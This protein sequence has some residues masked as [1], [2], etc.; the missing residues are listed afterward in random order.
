MT[1]KTFPY[2][3]QA[4]SYAGA[5]LQENWGRL[6]RGDCEPFPDDPKVAGCLAELPC[7]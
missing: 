6:H 4:Y 2:P 3:D 7:G 5:A 1:W